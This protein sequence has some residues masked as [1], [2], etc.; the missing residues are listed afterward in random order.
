MCAVALVA[1]EDLVAAVADERDLDVPPRRLADEQRRQRRLVAERL[2]EGVRE[3]LEEL[4]A[5]VDLD[6]L[7][8]RAV[9]LGDRAG[10][11]PLVVARVGE[12]DGE[13]AHRLGRGL[14]HRRDDDR[15]VDPAGE[16][17]AERHVGDEPPPHRRRHLV[18]HPLDP[19]AL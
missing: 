15:R 6:L 16:Q 5:G 13:R 1:A 11:G 7:V 8:P 19:V 2:V 4:R 9:A 17:R 18:A 3:P 12:A 10:V 14:R